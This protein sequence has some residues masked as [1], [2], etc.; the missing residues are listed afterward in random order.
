MKTISRKIGIL[1][2]TESNTSLCK[3]TILKELCDKV[4]FYWIANQDL[5]KGNVQKLNLDCLVIDEQQLEKK[6]S[7]KKLFIQLCSINF[8][9]IVLLIKDNDKKVIEYLKNNVVDCLLSSDLKTKSL[10]LAIHKAFL[11]KDFYVKL[12]RKEDRAKHLAYHDYLT[13]L[14]NRMY[15]DQVLIRSISRSKRTNVSLA[16]CMLDLDGFKKVN[17]ELGHAAGDLL[18]KK[19][20]RIFL[21]SIRKSDLLARFGGDEF[22]IILYDVDLVQEAIFICEKIISKFKE[23][24]ILLGHKINV[25]TSIGLAYFDKNIQSPNQLVKN[26]D[27]ALYTAKTSGKNKYQFYSEDKNDKLVLYSSLK[28]EIE[29]Q[30]HNNQYSIKKTASSTSNLKSTIFYINFNRSL[31]EVDVNSF[32]EEISL[33]ENHLKNFILHLD[34]TL[35]QTEG[36]KLFEVPKKH[37]F[38]PSILAVLKNSLLD[39]IIVDVKQPKTNSIPDEVEYS[40][41]NKP[42]YLKNFFEHSFSCTLLEQ[43]KP[44][45]VIINFQNLYDHYQAG[46]TRF[47]KVL[48]EIRIIYNLNFIFLVSNYFFNEKKDMIH[49][50]SNKGCVIVF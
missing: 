38:N 32:Y 36:L 25:S 3:E 15:F 20:S 5:S 19:V 4:S 30:I 21:K 42:L 43:Y 12:Q 35:R 39:A 27:S 9:I 16:V 11:Q 33:S 23:P 26:A 48:D 40:L 49:S 1:G 17:D 8:P 18:L 7:I 6:P 24:L 2:L 45:G 31:S 37:L 47:L 34:E 14:P 28:K 41:I 22:S 50:L 13:G 46:T 44:M 29:N 10:S